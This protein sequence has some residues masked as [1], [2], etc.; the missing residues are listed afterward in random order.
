MERLDDKQLAIVLT[1]CLAGGNMVKAAQAEAIINAR[2][3]Q[4]QQGGGK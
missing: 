2:R 4:T 1:S 3:E